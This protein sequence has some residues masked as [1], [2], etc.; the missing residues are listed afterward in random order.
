MLCY[1]C[2]KEFE[3]DG[4]LACKPCGE[5]AYP[6]T[7]KRGSSR[8]IREIQERLRE[9]AHGAPEAF[10]DQVYETLF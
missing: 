6:S 4:E 2:K 8:S 7:Q 10:E 1:V 9:M 3:S 5:A